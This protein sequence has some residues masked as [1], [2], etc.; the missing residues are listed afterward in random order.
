MIHATVFA[1]SLIVGGG[2]D[3]MLTACI[4]ELVSCFKLF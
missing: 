2:I 3:P 1:V 4:I